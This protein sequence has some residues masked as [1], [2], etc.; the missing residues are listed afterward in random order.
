[1][2]GRICQL[3]GSLLMLLQPATAFSSPDHLDAAIRR[4]EMATIRIQHK[5]KSQKMAEGVGFFVARTGEL[6]APSSLVIP[7]LRSGGSLEFKLAN[8]QTFTSFTISTC[9]DEDSVPE[10]CI[11]KID[12]EAPQY[13]FVAETQLTRDEVLSGVLGEDDKVQIAL[14]TPTAMQNPVGGMQDVVFSPAPKATS[15]VPLVTTRGELSGIVTAKAGGSAVKVATSNAIYTMRA[16]NKTFRTAREFGSEL[17][18]ILRSKAVSYMAHVINPAVTI[19]AAGSIPSR[20]NGFREHSFDFSNDPFLA[21]IPDEFTSCQ[22]GDVNTDGFVCTTR[23]DAWKLFVTRQTVRPTV[24]ITNLGGQGGVVCSGVKWPLAGSTFQASSYSCR[25]NLENDREPSA[26]SSAL[27]VDSYQGRY[28]IKFWTR[29][30]IWRDLAKLMPITIARSARYPQGIPKVAGTNTPP[31]QTQPTQPIATTLPPK[32]KRKGKGPTPP[33]RRPVSELPDKAPQPKRSKTTYHLP[34]PSYG[35]QVLLEVNFNSCHGDEA[36]FIDTYSHTQK[37]V[38]WKI[39][40]GRS[41]VAYKAS[42][43]KSAVQSFLKSYAAKLGAKL[44][45]DSIQVSQAN[46]APENPSWIVNGFGQI[47]GTDSMT[48]MMV[49]FGKNDTYVLAFTADFA[50]PAANFQLFQI[51]AKSFRRK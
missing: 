24:P 46:W 27:V 40:I 8:E 51:L 28:E 50:D 3:I 45:P 31:V 29:E 39:L 16:K 9:G 18:R 42:E 34:N 43:H 36:E 6:V 12:T 5:N 4:Y 32:S 23:D 13:F 47:N 35:I 15:F 44:V 25:Y 1:M 48:M 33:L 30:K 19:L 49:S 41:P 7:A 21:S 2:T 17:S 10:I 14:I 26:F 20:D 37:G 38:R 22:R 11:L